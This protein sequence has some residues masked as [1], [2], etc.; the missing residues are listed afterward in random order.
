MLKTLVDLY[1]LPANHPICR[2]NFRSCIRFKSPL[3]RSSE[4]IKGV[5]AERI[6]K[7]KP[8]IIAPWEP[9]IT[10]EKHTQSDSA[11][12]ATVLL[13]K[14]RLLITTTAV[15]NQ[16]GIAYGI[17]QASRFAWVASGEHLDIKRAQNLYTAELLAVAAAL[18]RVNNNIPP[19]STILITSANLAVL[20]ALKNPGKQS[21]QCTI[22]SIY[23]VK[24]D[25]EQKGVKIQWMWIS[26]STPCYT[27]DKA[28]DEAHRALDR[29]ATQGLPQWDSISS[30]IAQI[31]P[32]LLHMRN[33][34][35]SVGKSIRELDTALPGRHTKKLY[36]S[37]SKSDARIL[38]QLRTGCARLNQFLAR[39]KAIDSPLCQCGVAPKSLRHFLFSCSRW[40]SHRR[41][42][43]NSWPGKE[44]DIRFF[45]GAKSTD[46]TDAWTPVIEAVRT[47]IRYARATARLEVEV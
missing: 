11:D 1:T 37:M 30:T 19:N 8:Y 24:R 47:V 45:L 44:G 12:A 14:D 39:I 31:T 16:K 9:R 21:G 36:D 20:Q 25:M 29:D 17:T 2:I 6:E 13:N 28:K 43:Y 41:E 7:I 5:H 4:E 40:V 23:E 18:N 34:P 26:A 35:C 46:D 22:K 38:I 27:R 3:Q 33:I 32:Q 10:Y 15:E 42:M